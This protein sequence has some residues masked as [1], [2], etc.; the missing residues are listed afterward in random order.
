[1]FEHIID[2]KMQEREESGINVIDAMAMTRNDCINCLCNN[3]DL[4]ASIITDSVKQLDNAIKAVKALEAISAITDLLDNPY[5][6]NHS[7]D[8]HKDD[9]LFILENMREILTFDIEGVCISL[10]D[11]SRYENVACADV[12]DAVIMYA[13]DKLY[14]K[15]HSL[16]NTTLVY[17]CILCKLYLATDVYNINMIEF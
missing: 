1:M 9:L 15:I 5:L 17:D 16:D 10:A 7:Y 4:F 11:D 8:V 13:A 12:R 2:E 6:I 3:T 14:N